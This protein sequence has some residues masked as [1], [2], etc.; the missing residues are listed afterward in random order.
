V[1]IDCFPEAMTVRDPGGRN[2]LHFALANMT[3]VPKAAPMVVRLLLS[4]MPSLVNPTDDQGQNPF[5]FLLNFAGEINDLPLHNSDEQRESIQQC[6]TLLLDAKPEPTSTVFTALRSLPPWLFQNAILHETVQAFLNQRIKGRFPTATLMTDFY[7][8]F[9]VLFAYSMAVIESIDH[10]FDNDPDND[11]ISGRKLALLYFGATYF[12]LREMAQ[13]LSLIFLRSFREFVRLWLVHPEDWVDTIYVVLVYFWAC[14]MQTGSM[15]ADDF[16]VGAGLSV[17]ILW[18]K[19]LLYLRSISI[20]LAV[21]ITGSF[22][23]VKRLVPYC[24]V[25]LCFLGAFT[26]MFHTVFQQTSYCLDQPNNLLTTEQLT[27]NLQCEQSLTRPFCSRRSSFLKV[28]TMFLGEVD[29]DDFETSNNAT[30]MYI[31]FMFGGVILLATILIAIVTD[32]YKII[33][34]NEAVAV[35]YTN[36]LDFI[37]ETDAIAN[38]IPFFQW[39]T[40]PK[41]GNKNGFDRNLWQ[42]CVLAWEFDPDERIFS[43]TFFRFRFVPLALSCLII[44]VWYFLGFV[45][46]GLLWP[47]QIREKMFGS[48][49][50]WHR[51]ASAQAE[52]VLQRCRQEEEKKLEEEVKDARAYFYQGLAENRMHCAQI[53]ASVTERKQEMQKE[54]KEIKRIITNLFEQQ[55]AHSQDES[56]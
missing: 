1:L 38:A 48:N 52:D 28:L 47:P 4:S 37:A 25:V 41:K 24:I 9:L 23:V 51:S 54:C 56:R 42:E 30:W 12:C 33:Q 35:F 16:R 46:A 50:V 6:L 13:I 40:Q 32:S 31:I 19:L 5:L 39:F 20:E 49:V 3:T 26:F 34:D 17:G 53:K 10:R 29:D 11:S 7:V 8:Q 18:I 22:Y 43:E 14:V 45:T 36:R 21:F 27:F 55:A 2:P 15:S 44:P